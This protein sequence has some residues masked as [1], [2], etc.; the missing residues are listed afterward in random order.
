MIRAKYRGYS[1]CQ[2]REFGPLKL[3]KWVEDG[4]FIIVKDNANA[5]PGATFRTVEDAK[6]TIDIFMEAF[7]SLATRTA[8]A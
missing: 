8:K 6:K 3:L 5:M 4:D 7:R 2:Q 1:I